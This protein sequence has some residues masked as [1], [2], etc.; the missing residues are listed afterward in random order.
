MEHHRA[1]RQF[2]H[3]FVVNQ[4]YRLPEGLWQRAT[5]HP[6]EYLAIKWSPSKYFITHKV[7]LSTVRVQCHCR[8]KPVRLLL[9]VVWC[10][11]MIC[12]ISPILFMVAIYCNVHRT[13]AD[14]QE[15]VDTLF[16]TWRPQVC[17][18]A[19]HSTTLR[20]FQYIPQTGTIATN[21]LLEKI[22]IKD[23]NECFFK[24]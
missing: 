21:L 8:W 12:V 24:W 3:T 7:V 2:E 16:P 5:R 11:M 15:S 19:A 23:R 4:F 18:F 9:C 22:N 6:G 13:T 14:I 20:G 17:K 10:A 1:M